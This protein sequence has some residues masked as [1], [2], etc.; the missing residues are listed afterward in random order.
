[1]LCESE[2]VPSTA[3]DDFGGLYLRWVCCSGSWTV[4]SR[5]VRMG[6]FLEQVVTGARLTEVNP[7]YGHGEQFRCNVGGGF[8]N[9]G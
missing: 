9:G 2:G 7:R 8:G 3:A 5:I 6:F 4:S 1:M